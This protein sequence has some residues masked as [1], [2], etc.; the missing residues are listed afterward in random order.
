MSAIDFGLL[1]AVMTFGWGLCLAVYRAC[2]ESMHWPMGR[3]QRE[4]PALAWR[5]GVFSMGLAGVFAIWRASVGYPVSA[6]VIPLFGVA[7]AIFWLGF[8]RVG[9]QS[10]LLL[11]PAG[12]ALLLLRWLA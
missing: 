8:L 11:A 4:R 2:A 3:W 10:A 7:W 9:A 5:M 12:A 6:S 1:L